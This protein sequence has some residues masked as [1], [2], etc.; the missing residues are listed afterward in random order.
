M[1]NSLFKIF[2]HVGWLCTFAL[3]WAFVTGWLVQ[4]LWNH[5]IVSAHVAANPI[6]TL[7]AMGMVLLCAILFKSSPSKTKKR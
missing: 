5:C 4:I 7:Q 2:S 3:G 6:N 1:R